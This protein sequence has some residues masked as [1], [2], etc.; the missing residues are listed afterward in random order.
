MN[1]PIKFQTTAT[2]LLLASGSIT[3]DALEEQM[4]FIQWTGGT[5][6]SEWPGVAQ[7]TYFYQW[8]TDLVT[9][10]Y[11]PFMAFGTGGHE[12]FM[13]A[14]PQK[15]FVRLFTVDFPE[16]TSLAE[17][18]GA[19]FDGDSYNNHFELTVLSTSPWLADTDSNGIMDGA[20]SVDGDA[21]P[22][23]WELFYFGN[24]TTV[25]ATNAPGYLHMFLS[26]RNPL[27]STLPDSSNTLA[28]MIHTPME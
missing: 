13:D 17:A 24:L 8:T 3:A 26:G 18:E 20:E 28:L 25:N 1:F 19:N 14:S 5:F 21:V 12:Y 15:L 10:H 7:R 23:A 6:K 9:W 2:C 16:I 4:T 11:A 22:D 27:V